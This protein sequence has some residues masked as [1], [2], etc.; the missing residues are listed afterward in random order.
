[1]RRIVTGIPCYKVDIA[2]NGAVAW[3]A[4]QRNSYDLLIT[5]QDMPELS[6]LELIRK[7]QSAHMV[8]PVIMVS[9]TMPT[10]E[11]K[12]HPELRINAI[13]PKPFDIM[14]FINAVKKVLQTTG[15]VINHSKLLPGIVR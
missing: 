1:M 5:D 4:L 8:L 2:E 3:D 6:G 13:L 7:I 10:E 14:E 12:R 11:I 15:G 9:G